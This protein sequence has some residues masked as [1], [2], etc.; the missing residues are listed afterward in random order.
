MD[1][2]LLKEFLWST[3]EEIAQQETSLVKM[4]TGVYGQELINGIYRSFHS[5]K[6]AA[7]LLQLAAIESATHIC[8]N[9]LT[10]FRVNGGQVETALINLLLTCLDG[11]KASLGY[12]ESGATIPDETFRA[13]NE[14]YAAYKYENSVAVNEAPKGNTQTAVKETA[15]TKTQTN[16]NNTNKPCN[17]PQVVH[18]EPKVTKPTAPAPTTPS[19]SVSPNGQNCT[20]EGQ[21]AAKEAVADTTVRVDIALLDRLMNLVGELVLARNQLLQVVGRYE[22]AQLTSTSQAIDQVTSDVQENIMRT[23]M[24]PIGNIFNKFPRIIRDLGQQLG[25]QIDLEI[26]GK[27][28]ELDRTLLEGLRDPFT[29]IIR[30]SCD[31]GVETPEERTAKGKPATGTIAIRAYHEGGQVIVEIIDD[32][33]GIDVERIKSKAVS[34]GII[35]STDSQRMSNQEALLL[36]CHPGFSTAEQVTNIS[37]RGVGMDVVRKNIEKM[38]GQLEIISTFG[39]GS[40]IRLK[41]PLTLAIIPALMVRCGDQLFGIPQINLVE[42]VGIEN[43]VG[44]SRIER[45]RGAEVYRL[46]ERLLTLVRL[47]D[48]IDPTHKAPARDKDSMDFIAVVA[49]GN[50]EFGLVVDEILDTE[51]IVVKPLSRHLAGIEHF[52]GATIR[53]D[54]RVSLILDMAGVAHFAQVASI[55]SRGHDAMSEAEVVNQNNEFLV[56]RNNAHEQF[57]IP[58]QLVQRIE[59]YKEANCLSEVNGMRM[60]CHNGKLT[61]AIELDRYT[62]T[63]PM[64]EDDGPIGHGVRRCSSAALKGRLAGPFN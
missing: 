52:A 27:E 37:G 33:R 29:H 50:Q 63:K 45:V 62:N 41:I 46:R 20:N 9:L 22:D 31:H 2:E 25:K 13:F 7:G 38:G 21:P 58:L 57:A 6:G 12:L 15:P 30:N 11:V 49:D 39:K 35:S 16:D 4:E 55:G 36:I 47:G 42:L 10:P 43:N 64:P 18:S 8:E 1:T 51:E 3:R 17:T 44:S 56:F 19:T 23:R 60:I 34:Q 53:G 54:G 24:Q 32:G 28:T 40:T 5:V 14:R 59:I 26:S 48:L 61:P